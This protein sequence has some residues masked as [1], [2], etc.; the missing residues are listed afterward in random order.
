[1]D[2]MMRGHRGWR[3]LSALNGDNLSK[4]NNFIGGLMSPKGSE[5]KGFTGANEAD[6]ETWAFEQ[7]AHSDYPGPNSGSTAV[8]ALLQNDKIVVANAGDSRCVLS[9]GGKAIDLS[10]DHKPCLEAERDRV[11]QAGGFIYAGRINGTLNLA[12]AIGDVEFKQN[13]YLSPD[14][15]IVTAWPEIQI[16]ERTEEDEFL[17]LACDGIWD[18]MTSQGVVDFIHENIREAPSLSSVCEKI[19]D[20]CLA[21]TRT[22]GEGCDNMT[23]IIVQLKDLSN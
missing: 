7:G 9:K 17:V 19:L 18:C 2:E 20:R 12:R 14:K 11:T 13:K 5:H 4:F 23:L 8:V 16:V 21:P 1:M 22:L 10:T 15:Q 6:D 3:E